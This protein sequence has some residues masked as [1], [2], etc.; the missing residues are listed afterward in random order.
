MLEGKLC[1]LPP[2]RGAHDE[3]SLEQIG[4]IDVLDGG[5]VLPYGGG[6]GCQAHRTTPEGL[7]EGP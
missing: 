4:L 3:P 2:L 5:R 7:G 6:D 1:R